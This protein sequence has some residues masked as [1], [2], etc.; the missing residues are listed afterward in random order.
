MKEKSHHSRNSKALYR[1]MLL[2]HI[3]GHLNG[4]GYLAL[5]FPNDSAEYC[6]LLEEVKLKRY[7]E[8]S[9]FVVEDVEDEK[10][11]VWFFKPFAFF[12]VHKF[13]TKDSIDGK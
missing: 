9:G 3:F 4:N 2:S 5:Y 8:D 12:R 10:V 1:N 6:S 13:I 11:R 7:F